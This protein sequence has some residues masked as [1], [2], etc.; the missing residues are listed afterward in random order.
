[1]M[2]KQIVERLGGSPLKSVSQP[3]KISYGK[4][5]VSQF[6]ATSAEIITGRIYGWHYT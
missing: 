3:D 6:Y 5:K 2:K 4:R 1:M